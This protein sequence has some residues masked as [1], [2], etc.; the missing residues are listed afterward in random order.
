MGLAF[1]KPRPQ[2]LQKA[3]RT[4]QRV[5]RDEA[6]SKKVR[7]R[8]GGRCE[9]WVKSLRELA[10]CK[11]RAVHVHHLLGGIGVRGRGDSA[12]AS[13]KL[14]LCNSCHSDL[15]SHVLVRHGGLT[16]HYQDCY[17]RVK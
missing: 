5:S 3:D 13:R 11:R 8:S 4:A 12:E 7:V 10:R 9:M 6:E 14:H 1:P 17:E 15:H 16:P 2:K